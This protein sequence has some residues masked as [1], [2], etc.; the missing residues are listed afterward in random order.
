MP[1]REVMG[2]EEYEIVQSQLLMLGSLVREIDLEGFL[3]CIAS[4]EAIGPILDPS[5]WLQAGE[6]LQTIKKI[7]LGSQAFK[8][9]LPP[10]PGESKEECRE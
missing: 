2:R 7:A 5:L 4:S 9:S 10:V 8:N 1:K 6:R 3:R